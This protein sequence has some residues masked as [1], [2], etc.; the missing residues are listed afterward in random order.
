MA[1]QNAR[2]LD[3]FSRQAAAYAA[4][5][6]RPRRGD[7]GDPLI[8]L[9][10]PH[11]AQRVLDVGCGS[12]QLAVAIAPRVARVVG[13]DLTPAMLDQARAHAAAKGVK[14]VLWKVADSIALPVEDSSFD[15]VVS[16]AMF[17]HAADPAA[18]F[19]EMH[20]A[21]ASGGRLV[22]TDLSPDPAKGPAFDAIETLRDPSHRHALTLDELRQLGEGHGLREI[23]IVHQAAALP[24]E[25]V[26]ATSF[27]P[28]GMLD[29][30]RTLLGRD[31]AMGLD[32]FGMR[33]ESRDGATYVTYPTITIGWERV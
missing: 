21:C 2:V 9:M 29:Q 22:V 4:L 10:A 31:A 13:V 30:V 8:G 1:D 7:G 18:T 20:R 5:V 32:V 16:R 19:G 33:A 26:L 15:A 14:N 3:Q 12:G 17:H 11:S 6:N 27:P 24:L 23:D 25:A 28:P